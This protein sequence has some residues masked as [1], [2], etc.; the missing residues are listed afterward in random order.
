MNFDNPVAALFPGAAGRT[1]SELTRRHM[2]G[3][4]TAE[5]KDVAAG[6]SVAPEQ[7]VKV[8]TRLALMGLLQFPVKDEV[9]LVRENI[10]WRALA[11]LLVPR[12][13]VDS[14]VWEAASVVPG[15]EAVGIA[16]PVPA[17]TAETFPEGITVALV[18]PEGEVSEA[19]RSE[20]SGAISHG[21][22]NDCTVVVAATTAEA[23]DLLPEEGRRILEADPRPV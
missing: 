5:T 6:A 8:A 12:G 20:V 19:Q 23:E 14:L 22:G 17:G 18:V 3:E 11:N 21:L 10:M 7:F 9:T 15:L 13:Y 16:G 1:V 4:V 2:R